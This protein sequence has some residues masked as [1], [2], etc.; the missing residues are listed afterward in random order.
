[1]VS[2]HPNPVFKRYDSHEEAVAT[3]LNWLRE[4]NAPLPSMEDEDCVEPK[5]TPVHQAPATPDSDAEYLHP[6][7]AHSVLAANRA[8]QN[9][10]A[11]AHTTRTPVATGSRPSAANYHFDDTLI[12][13]EDEEESTTAPS[14][15]QGG[16]QDA[17]TS[18]SNSCC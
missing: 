1:M 18:H 9:Q 12:I 7:P 8:A 10:P 3:M 15:A 14:V 2:G 13:S 5:F 6:P 17:S 4:E 11:F 16:A